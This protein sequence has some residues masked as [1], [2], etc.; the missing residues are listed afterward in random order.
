MTLLFYKGFYISVD[1]ISMIVKSNQSINDLIQVDLRFNDQ[2]IISYMNL[3]S[4]EVDDLITAINNILEATGGD[5]VSAV[6]AGTPEG[7]ISTPTFTGSALAGHGHTFTGSAL[8]GHNHTFTGSA[9]AGHN[10]TFTGSALAG[11]GHTFTGSALAGHGHTFTGSAMSNH[12]H[13]QIQQAETTVAVVSDTCTILIK[14]PNIQAVYATA[15]GVTGPLVHIPTSVTLATGQFHY[16]YTS[17]TFTFFAGD[18]ISSIDVTYLGIVALNTAGTPAGTLDSVS[19]GTPAGTLD[20]VSGGTPAG[21]LD[22]VSGG[23]P[24]GTLDSVS[25]GTP[26]G[27]LNSVSGGTPAGTI[28][29]PAFTGDALPTHTHSIS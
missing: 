19:G 24:A 10:H 26:A 29:E 1:K 20:S 2:T 16:D 18:T 25:G 6:S 27:T 5:T 23:T 15:G 22:S 17:Q 13:A 3:T 12:N 7:T 8:A 28:S 21:T 11:H 4:G 14:S 9:L